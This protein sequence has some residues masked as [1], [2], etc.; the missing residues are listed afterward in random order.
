MD[1]LVA[2]WE[3]VH[4]R[5][6][7]FHRETIRTCW[8][9]LNMLLDLHRPLLSAIVAGDSEAA[10][11]AIRVHLE[12]VWYRLR[13][14]PG[15]LS[16]NRDPLAVACAYLALH[17]QEPVR[18]SFVAKSVS[19]VS[20]SHLGEV[21]PAAVRNELRPVFSR[22][23]DASGKPV[24]QRHG[25]SDPG[26]CR[27][28]GLHRSFAVRRA[29]SP[30]FRRH[31]AH[32]PPAAL[33]RRREGGNR[34]SVSIMPHAA[35]EKAFP[36]DATQCRAY[37]LE[38]AVRV[39]RLCFFRGKLKDRVIRAVFC[40]NASLPLSILR[41]VQFQIGPAGCAECHKCVLTAA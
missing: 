15:E 12:V 40:L 26:D 13:Q 34:W 24:A 11:N 14:E 31:S 23:P 16:I 22:Y 6:E 28:G 1:G 9:D 7:E 3:V 2:A 32:L 8:P 4:R 25:P 21:V 10:Q 17:M 41:F 39:I 19:R 18:L 27:C 33:P 37:W 5:E 38:Y 29:F 30:A 35:A 36:T 20:V